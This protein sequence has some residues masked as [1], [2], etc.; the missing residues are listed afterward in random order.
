MWP[1]DGDVAKPFNPDEGLKG[2]LIEG[3]LGQEV[4]SIAKGRVIYAGEDL[5]GY[6]KL[7]IIKHDDDILSVY[8]H[9]RELLVTEGQKISAGEIISTMGQTDDGNIH[10]HFE[11][12]KKGLSVDPMSYFKSRT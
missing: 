4:K 1:T 9:N 10:L 5:K 2:I 6:G 3:S 8:G 12:R 7:I 11:I